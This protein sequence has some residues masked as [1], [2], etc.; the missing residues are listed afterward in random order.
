MKSLT[1]KATSVLLALAVLFFHLQTLPAQSTERQRY[2]PKQARKPNVLF[3]AVDDLNTHL[4]CYG[5]PLVKSPN[6]DRLARRGMTF[7]NAYA[8]YPLCNPSRSSLLTGRRPDA[9]RVTLQS[10]DFRD[11]LPRAV[12]LP[13]LFRENNYYTTH[14]GKVFQPEY[15]DAISW[16]EGATAHKKLEEYTP[17][18]LRKLFGGGRSLYGAAKEKEEDLADTRTAAR[19]LSLIA[20]HRDESFFIAA[21]FLKP[22][23]PLFAPAKYFAMYPLEKI[24]RQID[25]PDDREDIPQ[26]ALRMNRDLFVDVDP[27]E[28]QAKEAIQAYY[29]CITYAD[30][31][32]GKL[33]DEMDRL[34]L[35]DNTI[36]VL[37]GDHGFHLGEHG[38]WA[39][40]SVFEESAHAP[41]IIA[42]PNIKGGTTSRRVVEFLDIYPTITELAGLHAPPELEGKSLVPLLKNPAR[43]W[44]DVAYTQFKDAW[45]AP[46]YSV[47]TNRWRYTEWD[48]GRAAELY[49]EQSDPREYH[50]LIY[51]PQAAKRIRPAVKE[52][53]A[54]LAKNYKAIAPNRLPAFGSK[55]KKTKE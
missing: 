21:G 23:I 12:T 6:I 41:L 19:I 3:I 49:D 26:Q 16:T 39:K 27:A 31:Q 34:K 2:A 4:G 24:Q 8:N 7:L 44:T 42:A 53:H 40:H 10:Q 14:I 36:V 13:Q 43:A 28:Q 54:L 9:T 51:D 17:E 15:D 35:W 25:P 45:G 47:R 50:N 38:F 11:A 1:R 29:A 52:L 30:A 48:D 55:L 46:G 20:K 22:H 37:F 18:S 5:D 32:I 33:L